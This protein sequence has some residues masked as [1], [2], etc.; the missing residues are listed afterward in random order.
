VSDPLGAALINADLLITVD[1][2]IM[3]TVSPKE[4]KLQEEQKI[5]EE[6]RV[7]CITRRFI[8]S[9]LD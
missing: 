9:I 5:K 8:I 6:D 3:L 4:W 2:L 1:S 7:N